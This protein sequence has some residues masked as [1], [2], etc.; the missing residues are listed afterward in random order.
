VVIRQQIDLTEES[1][2]LTDPGDLGAAAP[3]QIELRPAEIL[4]LVAS[5]G[6][7]ADLATGD[8]LGP[9]LD[10]LVEWKVLGATHDT[11]SI[12]RPRTSTGVASSTTS[13]L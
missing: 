10:Q 11:A 5:A 3:Y 2:E 4:D 12:A 13:R 6:L 1:A 9:R 7:H 8:D